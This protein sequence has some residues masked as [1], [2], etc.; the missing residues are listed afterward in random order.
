[1]QTRL[2]DTVCK[3]RRV[4]TIATHNLDVI[5]PPIQYHCR[6]ATDINFTPLNGQKEVSVQEFLQRLEASK[7]EKRGGGGGGG[8][9]AKK[10]SGK[11]LAT[12]VQ[13]EDPAIA[14]LS[15]S[16]GVWHTFIL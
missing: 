16:V 13:V 1:M 10:K 8:G 5:T 14:A 11:S 4:A 3:R 15:K 12:P 7:Q 6:P 9:K 2:H